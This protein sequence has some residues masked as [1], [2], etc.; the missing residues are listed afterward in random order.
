RR[1][2]AGSGSRRLCCCRYGLDVRPELHH[3][4]RLG[5][6]RRHLGAAHRLRARAGGTDSVA[7]H[8]HRDHRRHGTPVVRCRALLLEAVG[9]R[10]GTEDARTVPADTG[11]HDTADTG[12]ARTSF[13]VTLLAETVGDAAGAEDPGPVAT[14]RG[15]HDRRPP[16]HAQ[17]AAFIAVLTRAVDD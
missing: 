8:D 5:R 13:G 6:R 4:W 3:R 14:R 11:L 2:P 1:R 15:L 7:A 12:L 9:D 10:T 17:R 16:E